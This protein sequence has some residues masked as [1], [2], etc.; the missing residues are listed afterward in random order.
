MIWFDMPIFLA[1]FLTNLWISTGRE[2]E[3]FYSG[4]KMRNTKG[5]NSIFETRLMS[6]LVY[7]RV[8]DRG[9][10]GGEGGKATI[11]GHLLMSNIV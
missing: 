2:G 3:E 4:Q 8:A 9:R 11:V 10:R 7:S 5:A 1:S 6:T